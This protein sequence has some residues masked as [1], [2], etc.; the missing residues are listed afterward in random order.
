[1]NGKAW[2]LAVPI[3][4]ASSGVTAQPTG[5]SFCERMAVELGLKRT[6]A[7]KYYDGRPTWRVNKLGG[8]G[9]ALFGGST[10]ITLRMGSDELKS[11]QDIDRLMKAC[12]MS[13]KGY[14]CQVEP[15]DYV[16]I[17]VEEHKARF[18]A[19]PGEQA[20]VELYKAA[21]VCRDGRPGTTPAV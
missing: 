15:S 16:E 14:L 12:Q 17:G 1:M 4:L 21:V 8:I 3:F 2:I 19:G 9:A 18:D 13:E 5:P 10:F 6:T 20:E 11:Q 7:K